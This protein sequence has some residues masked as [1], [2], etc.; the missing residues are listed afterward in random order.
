MRGERGRTDRGERER[1]HTGELSRQM[2]GDGRGE[3]EALRRQV[4]VRVSL[5]RPND[6]AILLLSESAREL[7]QSVVEL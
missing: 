2:Q 1:R 3:G 5:H 7:E 4:G 6:R